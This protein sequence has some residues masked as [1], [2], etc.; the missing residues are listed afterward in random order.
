MLAVAVAGVALAL[1]C[2]QHLTRSQLASQ[3]AGAEEA[4]AT[5]A[6]DGFRDQM[7]EIVGITLPCLGDVVPTPLAGRT[8]RL[9]SVQQLELGNAS[10]AEASARAAR[11]LEPEAPFPESWLPADHPLRLAWQDAG[12]TRA[13]RVPEPREGA[14]AFDGVTGRTRPVGVP[15]VVQLFAADGIAVQTRY[16]GASDP[17][18]DYRAIPRQRTAL[19]LGAAGTGA[20]AVASWAASWLQYRSLLAQSDDPTVA[21]ATLDDQRTA[22]NASYVAGG[23]LFGV[24]AGLG[25]GAVVMGPR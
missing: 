21:A 3:L 2:P 7:N 20:A 24:S 17:L 18:P 5:M 12:P 6:T 9:M 25:I 11:S 4:Y 23:L 14:L 13:R 8:H 19:A 10:A 22:V 1:D 15:T 16:L